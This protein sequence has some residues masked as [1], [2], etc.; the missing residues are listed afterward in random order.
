MNLLIVLFFVVVG[1]VWLISKLIG[2]LLFPDKTPEKYTFI[3]NSVHYHEH[4][5]IS[6]IDGLSKKKILE[7]KETKNH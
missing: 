3:D 2:N 4:K 1:G 7:L 6:I 5:S